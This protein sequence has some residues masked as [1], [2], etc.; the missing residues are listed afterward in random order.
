LDYDGTIAPLGVPRN[1][2][3]VFKKVEAELERAVKQIPVCIVTAKDFDFVY[4]RS[5][6]A[7][8]WACVSGLD[9][10]VA[11]GRRSTAKRLRK[12]DRA[13]RLAESCERK[14]TY[15]EL[16]RGPSGELLAVAVDWSTVPELGPSIIR[17]LRRLTRS[18]FAVVHERLATFA[19]IYAAL[20][21]KGRAAK[22]LCRLLQVESRMMF[23]G[24]SALDNSAF[25]EAG[26]SVGVAHGQPMAELKCEFVVDQ[27]SLAGFLRS[28]T[29]HRMEF[30]PSLPGVRKNREMTVHESR[31]EQPP[32][33]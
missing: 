22:H 20:P 10:R 23:I 3:R 27:A 29:D 26:V 28:L 11:D 25:Q 14:G 21:D 19:D 4:P 24:D 2:S 6:F 9:V 30:D 13:L 1:E 31:R 33:S 18:G 7:T 8:G 12:L 5:R 32:I 16:K 17:D 15:T